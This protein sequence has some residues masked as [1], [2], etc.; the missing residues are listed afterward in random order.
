MKIKIGVMGPSAEP[1]SPRMG[2]LAR[3]LG[4]AI[5][6]RDFIL[7]T[8]ATTGAVHLIGKTA[9]DAGDLHIGISPGGGD[10]E[11]AE[12]LTVPSGACDALIETGVGW[13]G[14]NVVLVR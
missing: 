10:T 5:A 3:S 1:D 9:R 12:R 6:A 13:L 7:L 4:E 2:D 11:H 14:R 8:G